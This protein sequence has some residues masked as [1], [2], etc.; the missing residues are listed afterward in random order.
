MQDLINNIAK[1]YIKHLLHF[2]FLYYIYI[3]SHNSDIN[4][5]KSYI[6]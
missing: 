6:V 5:K 3:L 1:N 2:G 4:L